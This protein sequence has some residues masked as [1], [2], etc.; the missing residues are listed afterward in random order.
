MAYYTI[1]HFL[2][3]NLD[4]SIPGQL[5]IKMEDLKFTPE[6]EQSFWDFIFLGKEYLGK[7]PMSKM[8]R[9]RD[10]FLYWYP[11]N[12]RCSG[13]DLIKN[14]LTMSLFNHAAIWEDEPDKWPRGYYCNGYILVEG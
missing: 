5:G 1:A 7:I 12:L 11:M 3:G 13:K 4:G 6:H 10:E 14:H 8:N 9:M 2:Q